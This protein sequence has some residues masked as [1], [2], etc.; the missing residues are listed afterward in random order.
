[1]VVGGGGGPCSFLRAVV[2]SRAVVPGGI[3]GS[4]ASARSCGPVVEVGGKKRRRSSKNIVSYI[5]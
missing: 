5:K 2:H 3:G 4:W 1:M